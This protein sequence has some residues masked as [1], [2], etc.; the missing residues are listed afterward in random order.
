M[1]R[2]TARGVHVLLGLSCLTAVAETAGA[3]PSVALPFGSEEV[4][5]ET[6]QPAAALGPAGDGS[7]INELF[8]EFHCW[9]SIQRY[10]PALAALESACGL[11]DEPECLFD[12]AYVHHALIEVEADRESENCRISRENYERYLARD[13]YDTY[14]DEARSALDELNRIC[15]PAPRPA[16]LPVK[17]DPDVIGAIE[18]ST[19]LAKASAAPFEPFQATQKPSETIP[20][21]KAAG[22][23]LRA[24]A[25]I[26]LGAGAA[27]GVATGVSLA[28]TLQVDS[29]L[30]AGRQTLDPI[31]GDPSG[32]LD[33]DS[34]ENQALDQS[35]YRYRDL[36]LVF[37]GSTLLLLGA[38]VTLLVLDAGSEGSL[39]FGA[40]GGLPGVSYGG[41]F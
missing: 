22:A 33:P 14:C 31:T 7:A 41:A 4:S 9:L 6:C 5:V 19:G 1:R 29:Q 39:S 13:P 26:L 24:A 28:T 30:K 12:R 15:A 16:S 17:W 8:T 27:A 35:R 40:P 11:A 23:E 34:R 2:K 20:E 18:G 32:K 3:A 36:T 37:G 38:G 10:R 25:W 21:Q